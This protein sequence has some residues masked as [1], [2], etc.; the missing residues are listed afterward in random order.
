[1]QICQKIFRAASLGVVNWAIMLMFRPRAAQDHD[2]P[3]G[4]FSAGGS[5]FFVIKRF[6]VDLDELENAWA[7]H[8]NV[9]ACG[10]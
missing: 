5:C 7:K 6:V 1:M 9:P 3:V 10:P 2:Y 4:D 8:V